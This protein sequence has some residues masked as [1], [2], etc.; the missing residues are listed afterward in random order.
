S[1]LV[2]LGIPGSQG[3]PEESVRDTLIATYN[4]IDSV[5]KLAAE[6]KDEIACIIIEPVAGNMGVVVPEKSFMQELRKVC[7]DNK[8]L[9]I[10]DEVMTG[11]RYKYGGAQD[12][13]GIQADIS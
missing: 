5:K 6:F 11:F 3:V 12:Y 4:N 7:T 9:L 13:F 10:I 1:G 2:T 8:I